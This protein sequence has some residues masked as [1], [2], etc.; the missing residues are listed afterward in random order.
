ML[1]SAIKEGS[2]HASDSNVEVYWEGGTAK[3]IG[4]S[5]NTIVENEGDPNADNYINPG[6]ESFHSGGSEESEGGDGSAG[7]S[8]GGIRP[9]EARRIWTEA[10]V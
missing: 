7:G 2:A 9:K 4:S 1:P 6:S 3:Q 10:R 8:E 5:N